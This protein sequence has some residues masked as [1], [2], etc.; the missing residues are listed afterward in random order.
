MTGGMASKAKTFAGNLRSAPMGALK[1]GAAGLAVIIG[2]TL[3]KAL[4]AFSAKIDE[5][6]KTFGFIT[7]QNEDFRNDLILAGNNAAMIGKNLS[8]VLYLLHRI[9]SY[10][11]LFDSI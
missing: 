9:L 7:N 11:Y 10:F 6:G 3:I 5:V 4:T 1:A 2:T 8:D